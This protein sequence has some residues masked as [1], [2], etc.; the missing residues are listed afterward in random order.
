M[1]KSDSAITPGNI[2]FNLVQRKTLSLSVKDLP[3]FLLLQA[4][5]YARPQPPYSSAVRAQKVRPYTLSLDA[6]LPTLT[7]SHDAT[8]ARAVSLCMWVSKH[9]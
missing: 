7:N 6:E 3:T 2:A 4:R 9:S 1:A 8:Q 5:T